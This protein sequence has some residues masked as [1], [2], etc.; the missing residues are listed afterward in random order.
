MRRPQIAIA[1]AIFLA[2]TGIVGALRLSP[3]ASA[4]S[5][6]DQGSEEFKA[7]D[8]FREHFGSDA[9]VVLVRGNL[10]KILLSDDLGH[11]LQVERCLSGVLP[12]ATS[13]PVSAC[14]EL[15]RTD[16]VKAVYGPAEFLNQ[17]AEQATSLLQGQVASTQALAQRLRKQEIA[18]IRKEGGTEAE[19]QAAGNIAAGAAQ[20]ALTQQLLQAAIQTGLSGPP[21]IDDP[22]YVDAVVFDQNSADGKPK[23]KFGY[24]F[25]SKRAALISA[26]LR[27]DLSETERQGAIDAISEAVQSPEFEL[28]NGSYVLG[29]VPIVVDGLADEMRPEL[30]VLLSLAVLVMAL[31]LMAIFRPP[32]RLLPL[33]L[34]LGAASIS[35]GLLG[36]LGGS[37]TLASIAVLPVLIGLSVDYGI[38]MQARFREQVMAG[39]APGRAAVEAA[40]TGGRVIATAGLA[41]GAGFLVLLFSPIQIMR[42]FAILLAL[43]IGVSLLLVLTVGMA[44][45]ASIP[46]SEIRSAGSSRR[47]VMRRL[48]DSESESALVASL[49]RLGARGSAAREAIS[50]RVRS[51]GTQALAFSI[52]NP[53]RVLAIGFLVAVLGW[54]AGTQTKVN[55][56]LLELVPDDVPAIQSVDE[57]QKA[58]G[59]SGEINV[60][61]EGPNVANPEVIN[62]MTD[63]RERILE[64]HG[65]E[66]VQ[67][68]EQSSGVPPDC[69]AE[70][71]DLCP[72][73]SLTDLFTVPPQQ[74]DIDSTL[75]LLPE[76]YRSAVL[77]TD[78][79][80]ATIDA[81]S[82]GSTPTGD[83]DR[84]TQYLNLSLLIPVQPLDQQKE[85]VDDIRLQIRAGEIQP[86]DG[87]EVT[88]VGLPVLVADAG[89]QLSAS[90]WWLPP[91]G[92]L[93]VALVLLAVYRSRDRALVPL[94]PIVLATGWSALFVEA[95]RVDLS[96]M[97]VTLG[98]L[99]IAISTEFSVIIA[100]RFHEQREA[101]ESTG[102]ALRSAYS[103]TGVAVAASGVTAIAGFA[104]LIASGIPILRSFGVVTVVDLSVA[105][106]GV[107]LVLPAA[108][109]WAES[110]ADSGRLSGGARGKDLPTLET[111][112]TAEAG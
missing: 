57:L 44:V 14:E 31:V 52:T 102:T 11:L 105:L 88:V 86:P 69:R 63:F 16:P 58:T 84:S 112:S 6:V 107:L 2:L 49:Q 40:T 73:P 25:P 62:W 99:V 1:F 17:T 28:D 103:R 66:V 55:S 106:L 23:S 71:T 12:P 56:D 72:G 15:N 24:L 54:G 96:P 13:G 33:A 80:P 104:V 111:N 64:R 59:V 35:F 47:G 92:L 50:T 20:E 32:M 95:M 4:D 100:A 3:D 60:L 5:L 94:I 38:Q 41:T 36:L 37:L 108:L 7:T 48:E 45:M 75:R 8:R 29:G 68:A 10:K 91:V 30:V 79:D 53:G 98:A 22:R 97:S 83:Q 101:G 61:V 67:L 43:G 46:A 90:R 93:A 81:D 27:P 87:V 89:A 51:F 70:G 42:E 74:E 18:R 21:R 39:A 85:L 110:R 19:A 77:A 34:A 82:Q 9:I 109:V 76:L 78:A 26:R 65:F